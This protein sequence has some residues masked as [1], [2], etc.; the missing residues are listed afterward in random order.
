[1]EVH[2]NL[3][4]TEISIGSRAAEIKRMN[5]MRLEQKTAAQ[6]V[7]ELQVQISSMA[8]RFIRDYPQVDL[9][10]GNILMPGS[11]ELRVD[12]M[13]FYSAMDTGD[14]A[15]TKRSLEE[16]YLRVVVGM[17]TRNNK[18]YISRNPS[19]HKVFLRLVEDLREHIFRVYEFD[20]LKDQVQNLQSDA[21]TL[22]H[23]LKE[24]K[25]PAR[26]R[27]GGSISEGVSIHFVQLGGFL[28][29]PGG[30]IDI[31]RTIFE[32]QIV[33]LEDSDGFVLEVRDPNGESLIVEPKG[34]VFENGSFHVE[35]DNVVWRTGA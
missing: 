28:E 3:S 11:R 5:H 24:P 15:K 35:Y 32:A 10:M 34:G 16:F 17:L 14:V 21:Q 22:L 26:L 20:T 9:K 33:S 23:A 31:Q 6:K 2:G 30:T 4:E 1:V 7:G 27:L 25:A 29:T 18:D 13:Q 12:L 19:R 8:R